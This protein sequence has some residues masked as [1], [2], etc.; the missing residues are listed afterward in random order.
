M[1]ERRDFLKTFLACGAGAIFLP[2]SAQARAVA[3]PPMGA[4]Q[5]GGS[6]EIVFP[7]ILN[8]IQAP[9]FP[10]RDFDIAKFGAHGDGQ[11]DCTNAFRQAI[12]ACN[13]AGGGRVVVPAGVF[14]SGAINLRSN[15]N[16]HVTKGATIT[17]DRDP[18]K[19]LP[20]VFTRWEGM[21]LMNYSPFIYAFEQKN[22]ALT[23]EG[24]ID[25]NA[26]CDHWWP[27]KGR[28]GCGW[29]KGD[30]EQSKARARLYEF[31]AGGTPVNQRVFGEGHYLRP[32]FIQPYRCQNVLIE[33][34]TLRHSPMWQI[35]PVLCTNVTIR[36]VNVEREAN[37]TDQ[38]GPN[39]DGC[40][41]ESCA[42]VLIEDCYFATGDDCIAIKAGR[43][44]DGRRVAVPSQNIIIRG[45]HME[46]GH[47]GITVGS[48][49]SGGVRNVFAMNC[50]LMSPRLDH[51]L[52]F[53]NNAMRGGVLENLFFRDIMVGEVAHAAITVD[54]NY[55][56]GAN[57]KYKPVLHN[58]QVQSLKSRKSQ[59]PMD[60]QG[61][62]NAPITDVHLENCTFDNT[63]RP[64][65]VKNV[66]GLTLR[67]VRVNGQLLSEGS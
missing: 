30:P 32:Q 28:T 31:V 6:W 4:P 7:Q 9:V 57:G 19:Y 45:C 55:E 44:D 29:K 52:R 33:G 65:I 21:E 23:G 54:F 50:N 40:D 60:L 58:L 22:I 14:S 67:N 41:P 51:G 18:K 3:S 64:S 56:E 34:V 15:V 48:E 10:R 24:I 16:L 42:D 25:G 2:V 27:W 63:A 17:F 26:D 12:E 11:R 35:H 47:G 66:T 37:A 39:T 5:A 38:T 8:R 62:P 61:F 36:G 1:L 20:L 53:K 13:R 46:D 43:N 49:I 59:Y